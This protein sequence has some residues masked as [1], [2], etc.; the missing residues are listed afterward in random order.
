MSLIFFSSWAVVMSASTWVP[1]DIIDT[2]EEVLEMVEE[3]EVLLCLWVLWS[4]SRREIMSLTLGDCC[5]CSWFPGCSIRD[6][7]FYVL[8]SGLLSFYGWVWN[9]FISK[10]AGIVP[11]Y[12]Q[13]KMGS[14]TPAARRLLSRTSKFVGSLSNI[15]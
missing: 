8:F 9:L 5:S 4:P 13:Y 6:V 14:L 7:E 11:H 10:F 2:I 12:Q 3:E 1:L 15:F